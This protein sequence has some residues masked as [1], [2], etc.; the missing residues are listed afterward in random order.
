MA[1]VKSDKGNVLDALNDIQ[2]QYR[3]GAV[4]YPMLLGY[5]CGAGI[6]PFGMNPILADLERDGAISRK[7]A[8]EEAWQG[9]GEDR[10][11]LFIHILPVDGSS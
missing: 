8:D 3:M 5:L 1:D 7:N 9:Y 10:R 6:K 4:S 2:A 11:P